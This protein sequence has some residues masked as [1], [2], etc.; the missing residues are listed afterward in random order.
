MS[1]SSTVKPLSVALGTVVTLSLYHVAASHA[2]ENPF[3]MEPLSGGYMLL[4]EN[5]SPE[6][7]C[8]EGRCGGKKGKRCM[9]RMDAD[10]DGKVTR[11]EFIKGH[12][13]MFDQ[14][15]ANGDGVIDSAEREAH[16]MQHKGKGMAGEGKCGGS[17]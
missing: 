2:A 6:G 13:A 16:H 14:I 11:E 3:T 8:G 7:K 10:A 17:K 9:T 4:A 1:G 15:D 12:E 5:T